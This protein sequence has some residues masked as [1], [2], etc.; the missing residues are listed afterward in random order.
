MKIIENLAFH[1]MQR[2]Q[3]VYQNDL[4]FNQKNIMTDNKDILEQKLL[5]VNNFLN[6]FT[7]YMKEDT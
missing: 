1:A 3:E 6:Q 7:L 2:L 5:L 4:D